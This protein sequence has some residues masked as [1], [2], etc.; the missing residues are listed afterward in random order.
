MMENQPPADADCC[1]VVQR[2]NNDEDKVK[3]SRKE[4]TVNDN[5]IVGLV[6]ATTG[7]AAPSR[8]KVGCHHNDTRDPEQ[9]Q[10]ALFL[11]KLHDQIHTGLNGDVVPSTTVD[12]A[13]EEDALRRPHHPVSSFSMREQD[14]DLLES[15]HEDGS[16]GHTPVVIAKKGETS[17]LELLSL[18]PTTTTDGVSL[19]TESPQKPRDSRSIR[20]GVSEFPSTSEYLQ[21]QDMIPLHPIPPV[22]TQCSARSLSGEITLRGQQ[23]VA[24]SKRPTVS[25]EI[26]VQEVAAFAQAVG[27]T[28]ILMCDIIDDD[29]DDDESDNESDTVIHQRLLDP[30]LPAT[31][32]QTDTMIGIC[33]PD[34]VQRGVVRGNFATLHRK[35]LLEVSDKYH[36]YGKHL[37]KYYKHWENLRCPQNQFFDWLDSKGTAAG[38]PLPELPTCPRKILDS[39]TVLY[40]TNPA[41]TEQ[42][43]LTVM[44]DKRKQACI[45]DR[46]GNPVVT[47]P[48]GWIFVLRDQVLYGAPKITSVVD[49]S[50]Q[51]FHHSSFFGGKAVAAAGILITDSTGTLLHIYPHSGHYRP[52]AA[53]LQR[54]LFFLYN[55]AGV[56]LSS[57]LMV[58][59][60]QIWHVARD[61]DAPKRAQLHLISAMDVALFLAHKARSIPSFGRLHG[62]AR[63]PTI[64]TVREALAVIDQ[65]GHWGNSQQQQ[66]RPSQH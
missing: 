22:H 18:R 31:T 48:D 35:A 46:R 39:D 8:W 57:G 2:M 47:G 38:C 13:S 65:G 54:L 29:D 49:C 55:T 4:E 60:Q 33:T 14:A 42:Y 19:H 43:Q 11:G 15:M 10:P 6:A 63:A 28:S 37:R 5:T 20:G 27:D 32:S 16:T 26:R 41:V 9:Q 7:H 59:A 44:T 50:T 66:R 23:Q 30:L 58:D 3:P 51:R 24:A 1:C 34:I 12:D 62:I 64:T 25:D 45:L 61:P 36:R 40:I 56:D 53:H 17:S 52:T 21:Q